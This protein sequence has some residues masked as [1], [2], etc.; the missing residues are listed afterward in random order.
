MSNKIEIG[1]PNINHNYDD[2]KIKELNNAV[3]QGKKVFLFVFWDMCGPCQQTIPKWNDINVNNNDNNI[4]ALVNKEYFD[5]LENMGEQPY[6]FPTLRYIEKTPS[7]II[8]EEYEN[9]NFDGDKDRSTES[10]HKWI[11]HHNHKHLNGG[12]INRKSRKYKPRKHR[13]SR[14]TKKLENLKKIKTKK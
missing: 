10:F 3:K 9:A 5:K 4:I 13:K 12:K 8:I 11:N 2:K 7:S 1:Y 6:G 14:K